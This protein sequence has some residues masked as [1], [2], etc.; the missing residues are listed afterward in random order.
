LAVQT[1]ILAGLMILPAVFAL[2]QNPGAGPGL[3]FITVPLIFSQISFGGVFAVLF[4]ICLLVA[5]LTSAM[6][7]LEVCV[8][9]LQN[10]WGMGRLASTILCYVTLFLLGSVSALSF[11]P[12]SGFTV[13]GRN[14]FDLLD[15]VCTNILMPVGGLS[16]ALLAGWVAWQ[17]THE[18]INRVHQ[19]PANW[20]LFIKIALRVLAPALVL[21]VLVTG[22]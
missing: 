6:S 7:L 13:A 16:V 11:G 3:V 4:Y 15:Y 8:A 9:Y 10:E 20:N 2:G 18:E 1:A 22:L 21:V 17:H 14:F 5:A 12:W 19:H